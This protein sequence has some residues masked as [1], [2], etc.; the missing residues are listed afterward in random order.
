MPGSQVG[1]VFNGPFQNTL[2]NR[3]MMHAPGHE[4]LHKVTIIPRGMALGA[5]HALA[6]GLSVFPRDE[7]YEAAALARLAAWAGRFTPFASLAPP[8]EVLL[9][10][11][12]SLKLFGGPEQLSEKVEEGM[13]CGGRPIR[14]LRAGTMA[15]HGVKRDLVPL[16]S[17]PGPEEDDGTP[18]R[19]SAEAGEGRGRHE[20]RL[21]ACPMA[22]FTPP[23]PPRS[24]FPATASGASTPTRV[25]TI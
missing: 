9:E 8:R 20:G 22:P 4:P 2:K 11:A 17:R 6:P 5:A 25:G 14:G 10:V 7:A 19:P 18:E 23:G 13:A 16:L 3:L 24:P 1:I 21:A 12:G 15:V